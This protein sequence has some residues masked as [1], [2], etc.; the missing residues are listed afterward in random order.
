MTGVGRPGEI[1]V[2]RRRRCWRCSTATATRG[3]GRG[4]TRGGGG[5]DPRSTSGGRES[6]TRVS[7]RRRGGGGGERMRRTRSR[8][9]ARVAEAIREPFGDAC[10]GAFRGARRP[11]RVPSSVGAFQVARRRPRAARPRRGR[12]DRPTGRRRA[13]RSDA[14]PRGSNRRIGG[15]RSDPRR[16]R[17]RARN[18]PSRPPLRGERGGGARRGDRVG[19]PGPGPGGRR[20]RSRAG[21]RGAFGNGARTRRR[22]RRRRRVRQ[23][24][25]REG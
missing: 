2:P 7:A 5:G 8:R 13:V 19:G 20:R 17:G 3:G 14:E 6:G 15:G 1:E 12:A 4:A 18:P 24:A 22:R 16:R 21:R 10:V 23:P 11:F 9:R 25:A